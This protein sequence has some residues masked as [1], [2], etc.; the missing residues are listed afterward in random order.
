VKLTLRATRATVASITLLAVAGGIA[1]GA[2]AVPAVPLS[3]SAAPGLDE[4]TR[5][6]PEDAAKRISVA[7]TLNLRDEPELDAL[8]SRVSDQ[9]SPDYGH[10]LTP[11]EF[12]DRFAPTPKQVDTVA[13]YLSSRGLDV[14]GASA[15]RLA[16]NASGTVGNLQRAFGTSLSRWHDSDENRDFTANDSAVNLPGEIASLVTS[17]AGLNDHYQRHHSHRQSDVPQV[18]SGPAGGYTPSELRGAYNVDPLLSGG[19][20]GSGQKIGVLEYAGFEQKN[21]AA[22]DDHYRTGAPA[23][24]VRPVSGGNSTLGDA[25][26]EVELDIEVAH[27]IAPK[28]NVVVYEAPNS[29]AGE[30]DMWNA[31]VS[32]NV[33]VVSSSWGLCELDRTAANISAVDKVAKQAAAQGMSFLSAAGDSGAYD[34]ERD[35]T[36]NAKKLSVDFPASD[37]YVTSVGGTALTLGPNGSYGSEAVWNENNGWAAGGGYSDSFAKPAWQTGPGVPDANKRATP[38]VSAAAAAGQYSIYSQGRWM[39]V[40][41]TSASTPLWS[42]Y[43]ALYNQKAAASGKPR[44]GHANPALY[45]L[46]GSANRASVF[47]DV[48]VGD[49]R[50]YAAGA[51]YDLA[52]G[53]GS[54]NADALTRAL[55][56][57]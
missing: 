43:L 57:G 24:T 28:A 31:M 34:C 12:R 39:K 47:H 41:G 2:E 22:Y 1:A 48:T 45:R 6:G 54:L 38:D 52:T 18:G 42:A 20:D 4:A 7:V 40:G 50:K 26:V 51:N 30:I 25:Q 56:A 9:A 15:N 36:A 13:D 49:N 37:P 5:T 3:A 11:E 14:T 55:L 29:D 35:K 27:A 32:D 33:P 16:V 8:V 21:V 10:Y 44:I 46:A 17:V 19:T 23:P 53:W